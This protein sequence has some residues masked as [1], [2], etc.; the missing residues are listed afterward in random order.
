MLEEWRGRG[1]RRFRQSLSTQWSNRQ[2]ALRDNRS[3]TP[4]DHVGRWRGH[5][6]TTSVKHQRQNHLGRLGVG[7]NMWNTRDATRRTQ[8]DGDTRGSR[9]R[10]HQRDAD[11]SPGPNLPEPKV[12]SSCIRDVAFPPQFQPSVNMPKYYGKQTLAYGL[13]TSINLIISSIKLI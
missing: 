6:V 5:Y 7:Y 3:L 1:L 10:H 13:K 8:G 4:I 2:R 11:M 9:M 12:F